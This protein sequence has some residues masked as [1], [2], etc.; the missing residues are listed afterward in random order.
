VPGFKKNERAKNTMTKDEEA[1]IDLILY[2]DIHEAPLKVLGDRCPN[3]IPYC[4]EQVTRL[5]IAA[6]LAAQYNQN[7]NQNKNPTG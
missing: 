3:P 7:Q 6:T 4:T 1:L 5:S 2:G